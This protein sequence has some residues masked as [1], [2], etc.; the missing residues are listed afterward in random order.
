MYKTCACH[1]Q[2]VVEI[3]TDNK[4]H[5]HS[6]GATFVWCHLLLGVLH[7]GPTPLQSIGRAISGKVCEIFGFSVAKSLFRDNVL[8]MVLLSLIHI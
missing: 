1:G 3:L 6:T 2:Y 4:S 8:R 5:N 7:M